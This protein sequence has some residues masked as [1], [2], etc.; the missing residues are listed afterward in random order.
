MSAKV[1]LTNNPRVQTGPCPTWH[2][3]PFCKREAEASYK[4]PGGRG[5]S[6]AAQGGQGKGQTW[7]GQGRTDPW[8]ASERLALWTEQ[9]QLQFQGARVCGG[10]VPA[11]SSPHGLLPAVTLPHRDRLPCPRAG[12]VGFKQQRPADV[13]G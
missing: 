5:G 4:T 12:H 13:Y 1:P 8:A 6:K 3:L 11:S 2:T 10:Q 7:L 9:L